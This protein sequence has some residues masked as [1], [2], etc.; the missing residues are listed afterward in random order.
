MEK[1]HREIVVNELITKQMSNGVSKISNY[2]KNAGNKFE[3]DYVRLIAR[4]YLPINLCENLDFRILCTH[5][6]PKHV[7]VGREAISSRILHEFSRLKAFFMMELKGVFF[8]ITCDGWTSRADDSYLGVTIHWIDSKGMLR[9]LA[10]GIIKRVGTS[11]AEDYL[12]DLKK[13]SAYG[14]CQLSLA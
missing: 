13:C 9:K 10:L 2:L 1:C 8:S 7:P 12:R 4:S 14:N 3:D 6:N 5:L 11:T